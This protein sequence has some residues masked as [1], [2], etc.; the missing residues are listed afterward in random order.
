MNNSPD[1]LLKMENLATL[2]SAVFPFEARPDLVREGPD[3]F[4]LFS[5][6]G[7]QFYAT[8]F[9]R[10]EIAVDLPTT[11]TRKNLQAAILRASAALCV[12]ADEGMR[13]ELDAGRIPV[14]PRESVR[15][16]LDGSVQEFMPAAERWELCAAA[17]GNVI[18]VGFGRKKAQGTT[19]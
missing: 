14:Q 16:Y 5:A 3:G 1:D 7:R 12:D 8:A 9:R 15:A 6:K 11:R 17:G 13:V 19:S 10:A 4:L 2:G 18:S